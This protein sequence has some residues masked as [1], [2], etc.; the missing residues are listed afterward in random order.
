MYLIHKFLYIYCNTV[1]MAIE[2]YFLTMIC[3]WRGGILINNKRNFAYARSV[4]R[5]LIFLCPLKLS[6]YFLI[7]TATFV[8]PPGLDHGAIKVSFFKRHKEVHAHC[9]HFKMQYLF[10]LIKLNLLKVEVF[11]VKANSSR[12]VNS[13]LSRNI[14]VEHLRDSL[15]TMLFEKARILK[16]H[17]TTCVIATCFE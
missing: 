6:M 14:V 12:N 17:Q 8:L 4:S 16:L 2:R 13:L 15:A 1:T 9:Y 10:S 3:E 11:S 5:Y 7:V